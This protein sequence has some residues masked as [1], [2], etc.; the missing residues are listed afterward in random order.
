MSTIT[1][2][3]TAAYDAFCQRHRLPARS[4]EENLFLVG[5]LDERAPFLSTF[6]HL[7]DMAQ[8]DDDAHAPLASH[9]GAA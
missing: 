5:Y 9:P 6:I 4:A 3:L 2:H 8:A 1:E 7:W